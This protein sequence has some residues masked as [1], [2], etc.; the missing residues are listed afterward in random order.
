[1]HISL[2]RSW[3]FGML[4]LLAVE[5]CG[6]ASYFAANEAESESYELQQYQNAKTGEALAI[7]LAPR[8]WDLSPPPPPDYM[9]IWSEN[10]PDP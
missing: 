10:V 4:C 1:M 6:C 9:R 3:L 7:P 2:K 5:G 8:Y